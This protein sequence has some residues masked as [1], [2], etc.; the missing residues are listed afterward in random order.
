MRD[1]GP[2]QI[3]LTSPRVIDLDQFL[4]YASRGLTPSADVVAY[5]HELSR[6]SHLAGL[7]F[8]A[9]AAQAVEE[10]ADFSSQDWLI[11]RNPAGLGHDPDQP[12]GLSFANGVDAARAHLVHLGAY[13]WGVQLP[14]A[15]RPYQA[16]D[17]LFCRVIAAGYGGTAK[18]VAD[19]TGTWATDPQYGANI[20]A[21]YAT[22]EAAPKSQAAPVPPADVTSLLPPIVHVDGCLNWHPRPN[23][24]SPV[25]ICHHITD[26]LSL[27]NVLNWFC[28]TASRASAHFVIDRDEDANGFATAHQL[29]S[30]VNAAW[31]NGDYA[32]QMPDGSWRLNQWRTDIPWLVDAIGQCMA[33]THNLNDFTIGIEYL[34]TPGDPPTPAQYKTGAALD[35]YFTDPRVYGIKRTRGRLIRH[36]DI[37]HI[38]RAY[39]PG[40][41]FDV[42]GII[43]AIGGDVNDL[44]S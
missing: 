17:P 26:D 11:R 10:T 3:S 9:A 18:T 4:H 6:L 23:G 1:P 24:M 22:L 38:D 14:P 7:N 15:L 2:E 30:S 40:P 28:T 19:L 25:A 29:V 21:V 33:G 16:I 32:T 37:D 34:G 12:A 36:A 41:Q 44:S 13:V 39:C 5:A 43:T 31:T 42:A 20:A 8:G 35:R 27:Q